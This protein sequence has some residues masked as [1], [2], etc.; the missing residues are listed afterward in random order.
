MDPLPLEDLKSILLNAFSSDLSTD[1]ST[2][3]KSYTQKL[4]PNVCFIESGAQLD[5]IYVQLSGT[6]YIVNYTP[7]GKRIIADTLHGG[8]IY[9]LIEALHH[10]KTYIGNVITLSPC[11]LAKVPCNLF[12][13]ALKH[14]LFLSN[15]ALGYMADFSAK[16]MESSEQKSAASPMENFLFYLYHRSIQQPLPCYIK[17]N[18]SFIADYLGIDKRSLYRYLNQFEKEGYLRREKQA[19]LISEENLHLIKKRLGF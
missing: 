12:L 8:Q 9:G 5:Y 18:K 6:S 17:E 15:L 4:K 11:M 16:L 2:L 7:K 19:I 10:R 13:S 3:T 14:D 1:I